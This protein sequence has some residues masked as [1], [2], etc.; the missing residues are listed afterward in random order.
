MA[1][2]AASEVPSLAAEIREHRIYYEVQRETAQYGT[3][4]VTVALQIWLWATVP[5]KAGSLPGEPG[6]RAALAAL[7]AAAAEAIAQGAVSPAPDV[8]P[9]HW[10]LYESRHVPDA[11]EIRIEV[12]LRAAPGNDPEQAARE[13]ALAALR[14]GLRSLG[15]FEGSWRAAVPVA[16][17]APEAPA[18]DAWSTRAAQ[19]VFSPRTLP[20]PP[21]AGGEEQRKRPSVAR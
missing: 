6:C 20:L 21:R 3:S 2:P 19:D 9:F 13:R 8:E 14:H 16:A 10:A 12:N 4:R 17:V 1:R 5:K 15:V 18:Q 7:R 11:D